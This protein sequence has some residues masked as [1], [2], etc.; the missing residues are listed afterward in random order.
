MANNAANGVLSPVFGDVLALVG[1]LGSSGVVGDSSF[2]LIVTVCPSSL[3][4]L[5]SA[6]LIGSSGLVTSYNSSK[7]TS[8]LPASSL[9]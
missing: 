3:M 7:V 8:S 9:A 4:S 1:V 6:T 2:S 5:C